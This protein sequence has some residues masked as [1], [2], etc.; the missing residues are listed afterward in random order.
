MTVA[1]IRGRQA[2]M[3]NQTDK[4]TDIQ[5]HSVLLFAFRPSAFSVLDEFMHCDCGVY[6]VVG[7]IQ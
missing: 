2:A 6:R 5:M 1:V 3:Q 4:Q 7:F